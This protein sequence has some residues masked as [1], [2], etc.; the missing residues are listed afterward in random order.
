MAKGRKSQE[1]FLALA[2]MTHE[3]Q[4]I[5]ALLVAKAEFETRLKL[6]MEKT[7]SSSSVHSD[8]NSSVSVPVRTRGEVVE[9]LRTLHDN[10]ATAEG[11]KEFQMCATLQEEIDILEAELELLPSRAGK[12]EFKIKIGGSFPLYWWCFISCGVLHYTALASFYYTL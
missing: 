6:Q 12:S 8:S 3:V 11:K 1:D 10:L 2:R 5:Q 4:E 7:E 9:L